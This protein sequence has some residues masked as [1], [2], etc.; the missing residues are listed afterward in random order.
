MGHT[1]LE[2]SLATR[3]GK[4]LT[5]GTIWCCEVVGQQFLTA[6]TAKFQ[7]VRK[8]QWNREQVSVFVV[9]VLQR[10]PTVTR[11][12]NIWLRLTQRM[13]IWADRCYTALIDDTELEA[14]G[15]ASCF[16]KDNEAAA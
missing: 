10:T 6:L 13:K 12:R 9:T 5:N 15:G 3:P 7:G 2:G 11:A 1:S 4:S 8:W 16:P 14:Q